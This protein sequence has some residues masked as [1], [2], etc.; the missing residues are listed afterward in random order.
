MRQLSTVWLSTYRKTVA[1]YNP[2]P[3]P[4]K[5][6]QNTL[7]QSGFQMLGWLGLVI[8]FVM[9]LQ[10]FHLGTHNTPHFSSS[11]STPAI[12]YIHKDPKSKLESCFISRDK[13]IFF[14]W[15]CTSTNVNQNNILDG[16]I[17]TSVRIS[18]S[19]CCLV[20]IYFDLHCAYS[21][22]ASDCQTL[23]RSSCTVCKQKVFH[24]C[25]WTYDSLTY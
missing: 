8:L 9:Q 7:L 22:D 4:L 19:N 5:K 15:I 17:M 6:C 23:C 2:P 3:H 16:S 18:A 11:A 24:Q 20:L 13:F 21:C 25:G 14:I 1:N 10:M 12:T